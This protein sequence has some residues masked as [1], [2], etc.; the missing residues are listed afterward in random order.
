MSR[1][2]TPALFQA[3]AEPRSVV[4]F[5]PAT[6][7]A[8]LMAARGER[9]LARLGYRIEDAGAFADCPEPVKDMLIGARLYPELLHTQALRELRHLRLA[10]E[11]L[12]TDLILLKGGAY[13]AAGLPLARGRPLRDLDVLVRRG[14]IGTVESRL[15]T[16]GWESQVENDYDQRYYREWM[17]EIPPL[18][19]P[20]RG[21]E[22]DVHHTILPLT[23]RLH[24][25]PALFW[26]SSVPVEGMPGVRVLGPTDMVLHTATHLF[27]D[28]EIRGGLGDLLDIDSLL[29]HFSSGADFWRDLLTRAAQL[30]LGRP[31]YYALAFSHRLLSTPIPDAVLDEAR[32][33]F[34]PNGLVDRLME[35]LVTRVLRPGSAGRTPVSD[36]LLY[37]RS[38]WLRMPPHLLFPHLAR[39][40][41]RRLLGSKDAGQTDGAEIPPRDPQAL[42]PD[43]RP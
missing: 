32:A 7:N 25:D 39:K 9:I 34:G 13:L 11:P 18:R 14:Q 22:V 16:C 27:Y 24:P 4:Q 23:S 2:E 36:W 33:R 31:L 21:L 10:L 38:H 35:R 19:H 30:Q 26:E 12:G 29:R 20:E 43:N 3:W 28:G 17:H 42:D 40:G 5:S 8:V 41:L 6:W 1:S 37:V 15:V